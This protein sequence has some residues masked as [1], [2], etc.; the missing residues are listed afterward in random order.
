MTNRTL[1]PVTLDVTGL[2]LLFVGGGQGTLQKL[3]GLT[4]RP[5]VRLV[6]PDLLPEV[7]ALAQTLGAQVDERPFQESDLDGVALV[8]AFT[9]DDG[10]NA[11]IAAL[12]R[13][14][15]LWHNVA[16]H[17]GPGSF[18]NPAVARTD[19]VIAAFTTETAEPA[20]A[21]AARDEYLRGRK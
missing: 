3:S 9:N 7:Q 5:V 15:G 20:K 13:I 18:T 10:T 14:R 21:V 4:G 17:R 2:P 19:G 8:Y 16:Q 12:C 1:V 6:A 11:R